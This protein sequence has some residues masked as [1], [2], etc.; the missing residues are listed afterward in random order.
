[1]LM[2]S[3]KWYVYVHVHVNGLPVLR[4]NTIAQHL[5]FNTA[6]VH[7]LY[8][9]YRLGVVQVCVH[10]TQLISSGLMQ[11]YGRIPPSHITSLP[12]GVLCG[13]WAEP[14]RHSHMLPS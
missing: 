4:S 7:T 12:G 14:T 5:V 8:D 6:K 10:Y 2:F 3:F 11:P 1:M 13:G 9:I